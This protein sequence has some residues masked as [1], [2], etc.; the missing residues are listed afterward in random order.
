MTNSLDLY[1]GSFVY[2][3]K[4]LYNKSIFLRKARGKRMKYSYRTQGTCAVQIDFEIENNKL[5]NVQF[6]GGCN[7]NLKAVSS[8]TEGM[9]INDVITKL[10]GITCGTKGTSCGDQLVKAVEAAS[11]EK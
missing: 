6:T 1:L 10:K 2:F 8:L 7:G 9:D 3:R 4:V 5:H 11:S